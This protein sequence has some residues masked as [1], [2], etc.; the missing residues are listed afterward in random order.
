LAGQ[1]SGRSSKKVLAAVQSAFG[2]D[3]HL[4]AA[5][6]L[7]Q[8]EGNKAFIE[9]YGGKTAVPLPEAYHVYANAIIRL[10]AE[11]EPLRDIPW[12]AY[13]AYGQYYGFTR[14][15]TETLI[16]IGVRVDKEILADRIAKAKRANRNGNTG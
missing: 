1:G 6:R 15:Q 14:D 7:A 2:T 3:R 5:L 4:N 10:D 16:E 13:V 11:R 12:S 9:Q 8:R